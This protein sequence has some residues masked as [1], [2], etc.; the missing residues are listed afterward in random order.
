MDTNTIIWTAVVVAIGSALQS[1]AG[2]GFGLLVMPLLLLVAGLPPH[3]AI[4]VVIVTAASQFAAGLIHHRQK[5]PWR[6]MAWY[7]VLALAG[8]PVGVLLLELISALEPGRIRQVF[9]GLVLV[10]VLVYGWL[11]P[12]PRPQL[13]PAWAWLAMPMTGLMGGMAG[14]PGPPLA[15]WAVAHDWPA[16]RMRATMWVVFLSLGPF[17]LALLTCRFGVEVLRSAL[18][19]LIFV[20]VVLVAAVPGLWLAGKLPARA[21]RLACLV[22]LVAT[23]LSAIVLPLIPSSN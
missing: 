17:S 3:L 11:R 4:P 20:P 7:V 19:G 1:A 8:L 22:L 12:R 5:L 9:G 6:E 14:L 21:V 23:A 10:S 15:L 16:N 2:F 18:W 13:H